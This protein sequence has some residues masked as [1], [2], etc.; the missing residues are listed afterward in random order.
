VSERAVHLAHRGVDRAIASVGLAGYPDLFR[1]NEIECLNVP[2]DFITLLRIR[3]RI[4]GQFCAVI[5][6]GQRLAA[7]WGSISRSSTGGTGGA[8]G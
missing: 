2:N 6:S 4:L 1:I 3:R 5:G 7:G 8:A